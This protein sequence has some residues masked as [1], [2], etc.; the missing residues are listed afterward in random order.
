M[1]FI[2][3]FQKLSAG[4]GGLARDPDENFLFGVISHI[5]VSEILQV[6]LIG[7]RDGIKMVWERGYQIITCYTDSLNA[8][9]L[10]KDQREEF[11]GYASIIQDIKDLLGLP[12]RIELRHTLREGN[13]CRFPRQTE[14]CWNAA[15]PHL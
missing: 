8:V 13:Q 1:Q 11:H 6:E 10:I 5:G 12:G 15:P 7:I 14:C 3:N 9:K 4:F 2:Y